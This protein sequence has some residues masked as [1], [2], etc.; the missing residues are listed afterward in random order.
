MHVAICLGH[1]MTVNNYDLT[2]I[3]HNYRWP[4]PMPCWRRP[5]YVDEDKFDPDDREYC[6]V[7]GVK[8]RL[9]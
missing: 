3:N 1:R 4:V 2:F 8:F 6:Y 9:L 7:K 5:D